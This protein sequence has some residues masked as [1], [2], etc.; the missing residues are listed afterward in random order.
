VPSA[1]QKS[2]IV[3]TTNAKINSSRGRTDKSVHHISI[4][5]SQVFKQAVVQ[6][7]KE[8]GM[9]RILRLALVGF[10]ITG[11][12]QAQTG[13]IRGTVQDRNDKTPVRSATVKI[14]SVADSLSVVSLVTDPKGHFEKSGL[15]PQSYHIKITSVGFEPLDTIVALDTVIDLH[16]IYLSKEARLLSEVIFQ[17]TAPPVKQKADTL[18]Y[19]ASAFKVNPDADASDLVKK[20]PGV[21]VENG[22]VKAGGEDVKKVTIDGREFFGDDATA[23]LRNLP[24]EVIDK[25]QVFDRLSDQAQFTGFEDN[26]T[27]KAINIVT[28]ANMRNGQF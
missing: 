27:V 21:T 15:S 26:S 3:K 22:T 16:T 6:L 17:A 12:V 23:A 11:F 2:F 9:I 4:G 5:Y 28:K 19:S 8:T 14:Q 20:M 18:E 25:I 7:I 24:A 13:L 10:F 1:T